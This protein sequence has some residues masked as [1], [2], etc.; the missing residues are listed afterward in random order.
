LEFDEGFS[1]DPQAGSLI[2]RII[3][4]TSLKIIGFDPFEAKVGG[5]CHH[6]YSCWFLKKNNNMV[7]DQGM[8]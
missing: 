3:G 7:E 2:L 6:H 4:F 5:Y 8:V 1:W